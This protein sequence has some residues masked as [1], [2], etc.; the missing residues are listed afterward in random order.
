VLSH[1][2]QIAILEKAIAEYAKQGWHEWAPRP[3]P[4]ETSLR[5]KSGLFARQFMA[6]WV[7]EDGTIMTNYAGEA[8]RLF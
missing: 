2:E 1:D 4:Y 8:G 6:V 7:E 3:T 5:R